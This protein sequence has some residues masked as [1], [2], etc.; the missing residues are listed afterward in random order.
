MKPTR[1]E[2]MFSRFKPS[3][4]GELITDSPLFVK[5]LPELKMIAAGQDH[6][7]ALDKTGRVW[8]MGDDTFG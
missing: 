7:L 3:L 4:T 2:Q 6:V 8:A 1:E 5:E